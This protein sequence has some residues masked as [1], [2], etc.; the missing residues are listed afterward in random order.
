M[1][2]CVF[3]LLLVLVA[4]TGFASRAQAGPIASPPGFTIPGEQLWNFAR[5]VEELSALVWDST[6]N[7]FWMLGDG[8]GPTQLSWFS[9]ADRRGERVPVAGSGVALNDWEALV[10][11]RA[12]GWLWILD[13][14]DNLGAR[15]EVQLY[16]VDPG[17][18]LRAEL[19]VLPLRK[20][21]HVVFESGPRDVEAAFVSDDQIFLVEKTFWGAARMVAIPLITEDGAQV[22]AQDVGLVSGARLITDADRS[23][24]GTIFLLT[25]DGIFQC[26]TCAASG[27]HRATPVGGGFSGQAEALVAVSDREFAVGLEDGRVFYQTGD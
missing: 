18:F 1:S 4:C 3:H 26:A 13:V 21:I 20:T 7:G 25:Y 16:G 24:N 12:R 15:P 14:G 22:V 8:P 10:A 17:P 11:D 2:T 27:P 5:I 19:G 6:N 23:P 9:F